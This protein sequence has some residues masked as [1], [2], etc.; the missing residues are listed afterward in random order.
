MLTITTVP[1]STS[2]TTRDGF[3]A[4]YAITGTD[5]DSYIDELITEKSAEIAAFLGR[6]NPDGGSAMGVQTVRQTER[7]IYNTYSAY[8]PLMPGIQAQEQRPLCLELDPIITIAAVTADGV[9]LT[10]DTDFELDGLRLFRLFNDRRVMW[11]YRKIVIDYQAGWSLPGDGGTTTLPPDIER[12]CRE[13][14]FRSYAGRSRDP[15]LWRTEAAGVRNDYVHAGAGNGIQLV[16][17]LPQDVAGRLLRYRRV[18]V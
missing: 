12:C 14:V 3:K 1:T 9:A 16:E 11:T 5:D 6:I 15:A 13:L 4:A 7:P 17:G 18:R 8:D 10:Q 2:L